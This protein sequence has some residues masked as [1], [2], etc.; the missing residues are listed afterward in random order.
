MCVEGLQNALLT[1]AVIFAMM[2]SQ[3]EKL[4]KI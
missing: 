1:V 3:K 4:A 2:I